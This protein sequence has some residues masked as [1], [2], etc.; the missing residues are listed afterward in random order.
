VIKRVRKRRIRLEERR[1]SRLMLKLKLGYELPAEAYL[2]KYRLLYYQKRENNTRSQNN[3][4]QR[5]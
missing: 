3:N 4:M 2:Y 1:D 5:Q